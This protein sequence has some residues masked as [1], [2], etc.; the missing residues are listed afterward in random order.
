MFLLNIWLFIYRRE[1]SRPRHV[2]EGNESISPFSTESSLS[3]NPDHSES[4]ESIKAKKTNNSENKADIDFMSKAWTVMKGMHQALLNSNITEHR[5]PEDLIFHQII[6]KAQTEIEKLVK[7]GQKRTRD[8]MEMEAAIKMR[9]EILEQLILMDREKGGTNTDNKDIDC[10]QNQAG[11]H[12]KISEEL[13]KYLSEIH[14]TLQNSDFKNNKIFENKVSNVSIKEHTEISSIVKYTAGFSIL[15]NQW[16][17]K[18]YLKSIGWV[19]SNQNIRQFTPTLKIKR[20]GPDSPV[21][22]K[23]RERKKMNNKG[24]SCRQCKLLDHLGSCS[25]KEKDTVKNSVFNQPALKSCRLITTNST[26]MSHTKS[27]PTKLPDIL[28]PKIGKY[29]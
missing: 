25:C 18:Q 9:Q 17:L 23:S 16:L 22:L 5:N 26:D 28:T 4:E 21:I 14:P 10:L 1:C 8:Q 3:D 6:K 15:H 2:S 7:V 20:M 11:S 12:T 27:I 19:T 13:K 29:T 24:F